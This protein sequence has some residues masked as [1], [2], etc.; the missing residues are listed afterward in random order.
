MIITKGNFLFRRL[1]ADDIE[2]VRSWRNSEM[3]TQYMEYKDHITSEM[4]QAW[5]HSVDNVNN[6]YF[7]IEYKGEKIGVINAKDI[8]WETKSMETGVFFGVKKYLNTEVPL[9]AILIFGELGVVNFDLTVYA[10]ILKSNKRAI[11]YNKLMGFRLCEGQ[12]EN[13]NQLYKMS[14]ETHLKKARLLRAAFFH[15]L[16]NKEIVL[17]FENHDYESG[18]AQ[19]LFE[20]LTAEKDIP[21]TEENGMK[22]LYFGTSSNK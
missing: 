9:L 13:E 10:H 6:M 22:T 16:G 12:E 5:F 3:I 4:Q 18:Y 2:L 17:T 1:T 20:Q 21:F 11:R 7:I 14:R 8:D 15:I 19:F